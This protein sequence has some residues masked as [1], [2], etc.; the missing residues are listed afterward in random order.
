TTTSGTTVSSGATLQ[1]QSVVSMNVGAEP[2]TIGG[3][4]P[5]GNGALENISGNNT[6]AGL[7]TLTDN[8]LV[9]SD[10]GTLN[11]TNTGTI[12]GATFN[13]TLTGAGNGKI[14][15]IVGTTTGGLIMSGTGIWTLAGANTYTGGT[16]INSGTLQLSGVGTLGNASNFVDIE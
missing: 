1:L 13:L 10:A 6:Y 12:T 4:G 8:T 5:F 7:L 3:F 14:S 2:L 11:L 15:S 16:A 9:S